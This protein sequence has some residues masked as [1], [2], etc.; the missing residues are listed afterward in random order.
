MKKLLLL[1]KTLLAV[2]L[3]CAGATNAWGTT[4]TYSFTTWANGGATVTMTSTSYAS[5]S[6]A[7]IADYVTYNEAN[8]SLNG[9]FAFRNGSYGWGIRTDKN[10]SMYCY[11]NAQFGV[12]N[13]LAGDELTFTTN[14]TAEWASVALVTTGMLSSDGTN[15]LAAGTSIVSGTYT[16]LK[17]GDLILS[18]L[19]YGQLNSLVIETSATETMG[20]PTI[21]ATGANGGQR[22]ITI[23]PGVG[24]A[25]SPATAT[26][27]TTDGTD[28]SSSNGTAYTAPFTIEATTTIKA[29]SYLGETIGEIAS[30]EIEAGTTLQ[31]NTPTWTKTSYNSGTG[32]STVTFSSDQSSIVGNPT[33]TIYYSINGGD[34]T[35]YSSAIEVADGSTLT[36]YATATGY[37]N[38]AE[39]SVT[40]VAPSSATTIL[41]ESYAGTADKQGVTL[42]TK[43]MTINT[44]D[45][46]LINAATDGVVSN[47]LVLASGPSMMYRT[48]GVYN[49]NTANYAIY[50][51]KNGDIVTIGFSRG[52]GYP[53]SS[54]ATLDEWNST[55][56]SYVYNVTANQFRFSI[57]RYAYIKSIKIQRASESITVSNAGFATYVTNCDLDFSES[58]IKAYKVKVATKGVATLTKVDNVPANTPV[59]LYVD[60]GKTESIPTM[61][62]AAA[63]SDNDLVAGT[64]AA[65]ETTEGEYTNMILNNVS[66][67]GFYFAAGQTVAA[68]RAY[69]HIA[70]DLAP[71][72]SARMAMRFAGDNITGVANVEAAAE[73]KAKEGKFIE[74]GKLVIVKNGQKF[75]AA[76]A[77]LY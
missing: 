20:A 55:S 39:G 49:Q 29:V 35:A 14:A 6:S 13:L 28:P 64:G 22:T 63:V 3:L 36:Y 74:N 26:Y 27:Y 15:A 41:S 38:S 32:I 54:D 33:A 43:M 40:A 56:T 34:A 68:N 42:E 76:G 73:A 23:T 47:N 11:S 37:T 24:S 10:K 18:G 30:K 77:K 1:T 4:E 69:L 67:I 44:T 72:T 19:Q 17:A 70:T 57:A 31:L 46:Y 12:L 2:A 50:G 62:G 16:I 25:S 53:S 21:A 71:A 51:V 59:L 5:I 65:V 45:Y 75:N 48:G 8:I 58:T 61:T 7:Y 60:G 52:D 66:G 9:R